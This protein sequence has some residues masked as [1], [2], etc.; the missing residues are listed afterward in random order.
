MDLNSKMRS[1][2][3]RK[4]TRTLGLWL[5]CVFAAV[6]FACSS[7]DNPDM[8]MGRDAHSSSRVYKF[9]SDTSYY[10]FTSHEGKF[11][12]NTNYLYKPNLENLPW[13]LGDWK[14]WDLHSDD[15]NILYQRYY[16]NENTG[17]GIYLVA[18]HGT[19]ES[20]FHTPEV[21][22]I[23]DGWKIDVRRYQSLELRGE[24]FQ[25]RYAIA[26]KGQHAHL[27]LY[28]YLWPDSR[29]NIMDGLVMFR[30]SVKIDS[31]LEQA[32]QAA[33]DFIRQLS[34]LKLDLN[35][36]EVA[37]IFSPV[38]PQVNPDKKRTR[39]K[40]TPYKEKALAWLKS[41]V[42][43]NAIVEEPAQDRRHLLVSYRVPKDSEA[44]PY[45][46][47]KASLYDNALA[48]IA[49]SMAGELGLAERIIEAASRILSP[50]NDLW[51][52]FNTHNSWPNKDDHTGAIV[53]S[54][55]S[56]WLGYA[57]VYYLKTRLIENPKLLEQDNQAMN[58]LKIARSIADRILVRQVKD[59]KDPRYGF[60]TGGEGRYSYR[61]SEDRK[62]IEEY[63][64]PGPVP[65]VSVE[66]NFDI[67]FFLRDLA[68]ISGDRKYQSATTLLKRSILQ[69]AWNETLHQFNRGQRL[70]GADPVQ[71]LDCA[72]W[73]AMFLQ[74]VGQQTQAEASLKTVSNY[75]VRSG[76]G[77]GYKPYINLLLY[78]GLK[79]NTLFF[80][81]DPE[82][83]W[84]DLPLI[85]PEGSLGV[86]M[87]YIKMGNSREAVEL[88]ESVL[89]L[90]DPEGGLPYATETLRFQFSRNPS[91]AGTAWLV[92]VI[93]ALE[94]ENILKLFWER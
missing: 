24:T 62:G 51:F 3:D 55:A 73:G 93:S 71:A 57:I 70:D 33:L 81:D 37:E 53:R 79:V 80:P 18:V 72:S 40:W 86:A 7:P 1:E 46:F 10:F 48:I 43:P 12:S 77:R 69:R 58:H 83:N 75:L 68:R 35:G 15:S 88:L 74:A 94:D 44:Y 9:T 16:E 22:Y 13:H 30:L 85:W 59:P 54:G 2:P 82:K 28:W 49:F 42:T 8:P 39:T 90:Q 29:R 17:A 34:D 64:I 66:H 60:F 78:E 14:G 67:F 25:V 38:L 92:M 50:D 47:S 45:V 56:A 41:Q 23:G 32:E 89:T 5:C 63:F 6:G 91:V 31:S 27:V 65:W 87:A 20:R 36:K 19:N 84:N 76:R 52:T 61:W 11:V 21:C 26:R 4:A